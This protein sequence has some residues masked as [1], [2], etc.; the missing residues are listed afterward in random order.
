MFKEQINMYTELDNDL[1]ASRLN[2]KLQKYVSRFLEPNAIAIDAFSLTWHKTLYFPLFSLLARI[3][4]KI[5]EDSIA[6]LAKTDLQ[7]LSTPSISSEN[8]TS[9]QQTRQE[10]KT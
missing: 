3:P 2:H 1:F 6:L 8:L 4:Q 9:A 7:G 5:V 10:T